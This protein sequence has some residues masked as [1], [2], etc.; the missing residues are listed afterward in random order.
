MPEQQPAPADILMQMA[1]GYMASSSLSAIARLRIADRLTAGPRPVSELARDTS[2]QEDILFRVL[3]ALSTVGIFV[4]TEPRVFANSPS[5]EFLRTDHPASLH[6]MT[7][8]MCNRFHFE[9]YADMMPTLRDGSNPVERIYKKPAFEVL[10]ADPELAKE[11]NNAMTGFSATVIP[12]VL[13]V[14]DFS[15]IGTLADIAGGHGFVI[16]AILQKYP[17]MKGI[18]F[19]LPQ[20]VTG[21]KERVEKLGLTD[22]MQVIAGDFWQAVPP[23]NAYVMKH[24]IHDWDDEKA[25][26]ILSNCSVHL[27]SGGKI[28]LLESVIPSGNAPH[29]GKWSDIEMFMGPGG[30]ERTELEYRELFRRG[31]FKLNR[32]VPTKS[33]LSVIEAV[34]I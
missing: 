27:R 22:R 8:W 17:D 24:I 31:G 7:V 19:D 6:Y 30:R 25:L 21:A 4:E 5:S 2:T 1:C 9:T 26:K 13:D 10:F 18:L 28:I 16:T 12:A 15:H 11:F 34:K 32:I 3:R 33:P 23:A 29:V 14:Y 20:V